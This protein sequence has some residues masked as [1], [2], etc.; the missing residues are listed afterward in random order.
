VNIDPKKMYSAREAA[1]FLKVNEE[2][3]K[4]YCRRK[5]LTAKQLGPRKKWYVKGAMILKQRAEWGVDE[6]E[7]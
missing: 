5:Q 6:I 7:G 4:I 3:V 1:D 2:T